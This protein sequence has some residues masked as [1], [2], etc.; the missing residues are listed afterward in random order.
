[1]IIIPEIETVLIL[2]PRTGSGSLKRAVAER[3]PRS[4]LIYRHMEA[5]GVPAGYDRWRRIGVVRDPIDRL[6]SLYR[7]LGSAEFARGPHT[8][9]FRDT[10]RASVC[11]PFEDW[12]INNRVVFTSPYASDASMRFSAHHACRHPLPENRK[13]QFLHL[14]PDLGTE[15]VA[16]ADLHKLAHQLG[17]TLGTFNA[18]GGERPDLSE[19]ARRYAA[20]T[21]RWE[22]S[23]GLFPN[24]AL[25]IA[26]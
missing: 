18:T 17:L 5:D 19:A 23:L 10:M 12:L 11:R 6:A 14:R 26:A 9:H 2:V 7:F 25:E 4:M 20:E 21:F 3:Y 24:P 1:M 22:Y 16:F 8:Q 15:I 13:S